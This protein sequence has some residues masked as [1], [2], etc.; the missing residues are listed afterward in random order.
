MR[1]LALTIAWAVTIV[2]AV[3]AALVLL[4]RATYAISSEYADW[5]RDNV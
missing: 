2:C 3:P 5:L 1:T 4:A